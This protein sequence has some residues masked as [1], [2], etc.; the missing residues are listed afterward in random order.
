MSVA[1]QRFP[2]GGAE[3]RIASAPMLSMLLGLALFSGC[4]EHPK[5][6]AAAATPT[7]PVAPIKHEH[8]APHGGTPVVLG[9]EE[10]HLEFVVNAASGKLNAY[11]MDG[12]L[13]NFIRISDESFLITAVV[14]GRDEVLTFQAVASKATGEK[15]GDTSLFEAN[16]P[17]LEAEP[18]FDGVLSEITV[19]SKK[20]SQVH[21]KYPK[22]ND[23]DARPEK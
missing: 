19:R 7:A 23:T 5:P 10:Y 20:F 9:E 18:S 16:A 11:V 6:E 21:F 8:K 14:S 13:E 4:G 2:L 12:E 17:W 3:A 1:P 22:G 15:V